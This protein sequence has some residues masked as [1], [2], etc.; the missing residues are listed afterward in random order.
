MPR[1]LL[2][3]RLL[4]VSGKGGTGKT[5]VAA[6]LA[7][8]AAAQGR[9][10]LACEVDAKG[11]LA[12]CL[13]L[14]PSRAPGFEPVV[15]APRLAAMAMDTEASLREYLKLNLK[16]P[17]V[18]GLGPL[19]RTF[20]FV[21]DAAPGVREILT[22]GKL[23]WEVRERRYD[24]VVVDSPA[25]GHVVSLLAAPAALARLVPLGPIRHQTGW[26]SDL[27]GDAAV[28]G[29]VVVAVPE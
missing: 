17:Y 26:I 15:V 2:D 23:A 27:L 10:V 22:V 9:R 13:G 12:T 29:V 18:R 5:T 3:R 8:L 11:D 28:T 6:G 7:I 16:I 4:F 19:A 21:A 14:S 25:S 24:L 20:D 1:S